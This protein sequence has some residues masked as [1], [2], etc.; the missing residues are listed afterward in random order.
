MISNSNHV[1]F[2]CFVLQKHDLLFF[3]CIIK[4]LLGSVYVISRIIKVSVRVIIDYSTLKNLIQYLFIIWQG[5][6][7]VHLSILIGLF[8]VG[9]FFSCVF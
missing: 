6:L 7:D 1:K 5:S 2:A 9:I 8:L 3:Q 4:Q